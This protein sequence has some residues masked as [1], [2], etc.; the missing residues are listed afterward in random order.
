MSKTTDMTAECLI[1]EVN[2]IWDTPGNAGKKI[3]AFRCCQLAKALADKLGR[4]TALGDKWE[5]NPD[6]YDPD[7]LDE[8]RAE[9]DPPG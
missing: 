1:A 5:Q 6:S 3:R 4:V 7:Y 8:L 2:A 9:I